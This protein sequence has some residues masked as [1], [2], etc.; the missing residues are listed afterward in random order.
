MTNLPTGAHCS[1]T[2]PGSYRRDPYSF[3][4]SDT[5]HSRRKNGASPGHTNPRSKRKPPA[6]EGADPAS[7]PTA[8]TQPGRAPTNRHGRDPSPEP[9]P[10]PSHP[11]PDLLS[12]TRIPKPDVLSKDMRKLSVAD[13]EAVR[14]QYRKGATTTTTTTDTTANRG[15]RI[16]PS[17][18][19]IT[20]SRHRDKV[21]DDT[22]ASTGFSTAAARRD[23]HNVDD[24][25]V[26]ST[27][28]RRDR[29][30]RQDRSD[31]HAR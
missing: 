21:E 30:D 24:D 12:G 28:S 20:T 26:L 1:N 9:P 17:N 10:R 11:P 29:Q 18:T 15:A 5:W 22:K 16:Q 3:N 6:G 31:R 2:W 7:R 25:D 23:R 19:N 8:N 27:T 14:E 4:D 13:Q